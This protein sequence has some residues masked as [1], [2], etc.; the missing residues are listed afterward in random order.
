MT[1]KPAK[2]KTIR[3]K[4]W[5]LSAVVSLGFGA[6]TALIFYYIVLFGVGNDGY[7]LVLCIYTAPIA[8]GF[9]LW[10][11]LYWRSFIAFIGIVLSL[12]PIAYTAFL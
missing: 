4:D 5:C 11:L 2:P 1:D 8:I 3:K 6:L 12:S 7:A 9:G 10:G